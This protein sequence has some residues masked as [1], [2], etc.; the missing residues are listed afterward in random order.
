MGKY[1]QNARNVYQK[2]WRHFGTGSYKKPIILMKGSDEWLGVILDVIKLENRI[3]LVHY[4]QNEIQ[5]IGQTCSSESLKI[6]PE[7]SPE[8]CH[9]DTQFMHA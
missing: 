9:A 1:P 7:E 3:L 8:N 6:I 2:T 5:Q 4:S